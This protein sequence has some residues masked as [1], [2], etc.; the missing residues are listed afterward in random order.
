MSDQERPNSEPSKS[1]ARPM[2]A[3]QARKA[4]LDAALRENLKRRKAQIR[5]RG[6]DDIADGRDQPSI[7]KTGR[8][9]SG[10]GNGNAE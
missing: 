7:F 10:T 9:R 5:T 6:L 2:T 4:R 1:K 8:D 3:E